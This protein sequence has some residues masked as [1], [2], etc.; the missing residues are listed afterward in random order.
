MRNLGL[1]LAGVGLMLPLG[2]GI[3]AL[4]AEPADTGSQTVR[5]QTVSE[6][7][8][9]QGEPAEGYTT[10]VTPETAPKQEENTGGGTTG[11]PAESPTPSSS[12]SSSPS[13]KKTQGK[14]VS[15]P[16]EE[17]TPAAETSSPAPAPKETEI[18]YTPEPE[19]KKTYQMT[20]EGQRPKECAN[21]NGYF[22]VDPS[23]PC[24]IQYALDADQIES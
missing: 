23:N 7:G 12:S 3:G 14:I 15:V 8:G 22:Y 18:E 6:V 24:E 16:A 20:G 13:P 9:T 4:L 11:S 21:F 17:T 2:L 5:T 10:D 1:K 19:P